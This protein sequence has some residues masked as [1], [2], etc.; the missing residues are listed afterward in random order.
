MILGGLRRR[1]RGVRLIGRWGFEE[2]EV[3]VRREGDFVHI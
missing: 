3:P 2:E 1:R